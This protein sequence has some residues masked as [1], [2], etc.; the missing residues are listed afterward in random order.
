MIRRMIR[1]GIQTLLLHLHL[2]IQLARYIL[3]L[4]LELGSKA[5][6]ER[7]YFLFYRLANVTIL[8]MIEEITNRVQ[9]MHLL[10]RSIH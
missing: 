5:R 7:V 2:L 8:E 1:I 4:G 3:E 6:Y 9:M 10:A